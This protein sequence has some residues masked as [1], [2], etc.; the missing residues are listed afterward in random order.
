MIHSAYIL[1]AVKR[2][3]E[4]IRRTFLES[5]SERR[6]FTDNLNAENTDHAVS[7]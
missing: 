3:Y 4:N 5:Q 7:G 6:E 2:C 1:V